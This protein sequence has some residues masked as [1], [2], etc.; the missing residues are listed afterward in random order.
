MAENMPS[1]TAQRPGDVVTEAR[2]NLGVDLVSACPPE[3]AARFVD[4]GGAVEVTKPVVQDLFDSRLVHVN[5]MVTARADG[6]GVAVS[7]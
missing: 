1:G 4:V 6:S 3:L 5:K 2:A 7:V